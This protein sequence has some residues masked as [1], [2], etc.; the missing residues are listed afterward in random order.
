MWY[1]IFFSLCRDPVIAADGPLLNSPAEFSCRSILYIGSFSG[2]FAVLSTGYLPTSS[3]NVPSQFM[4]HLLV[5]GSK[6][7][8]YDAMQV[9]NEPSYDLH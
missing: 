5:S 3:P 7:V 1:T 6:D 4:H 2:I 8:P 9:S